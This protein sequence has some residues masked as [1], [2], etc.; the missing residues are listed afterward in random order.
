MVL[1]DLVGMLGLQ[2]LRQEPALS[3]LRQGQPH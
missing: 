2:F 1:L 3:E